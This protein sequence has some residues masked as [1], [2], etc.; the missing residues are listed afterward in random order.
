MECGV[1]MVSLHIASGQVFLNLQ[2]ASV[3]TE[4]GPL[5]RAISLSN[6]TST[7]LS[8]ISGSTTTGNHNLKTEME[9]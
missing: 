7:T 6:K 9:M 1:G 2:S 3:K 5:D 8:G 4:R